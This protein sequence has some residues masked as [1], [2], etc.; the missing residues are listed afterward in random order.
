LYKEVVV[1]VA[2]FLR[3]QVRQWLLLEEKDTADAASVLPIREAKRLFINDRVARGRAERTIED[4]HRVLDPFVCWCKMNRLQTLDLTRNHIRSYIVVL[5]TKPRPRFNRPWSEGTV[6]LHIRYLRAFLNWMKG[7]DLVHTDLA[8]AVDAPKTVV[9]VN[10]LISDD[11]IMRLLAA[12]RSAPYARRDAALVLTFLDTGLRLHEVTLMRRSQIHYEQQDKYAW[13]HIYMPK[14]DRYRFAFLGESATQILK[15]Y[16][17]VR[18]DDNDALWLGRR[19]PL[20]DGGIYKVIK[21]RANQAGLRSV[22][23][24]ALR[25]M[26]STRWI[27]NGGDRQDL[28]DII[29]WIAPEMF[30]IYVQMTKRERL[31]AAHHQFSPVD[32]LFGED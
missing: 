18:G 15:H 7:E 20:T 26:F 10:G 9:N 2:S 1:T 21:R 4:Y 24:H 27:Q 28:Q 17:K 32:R 16:L 6:N 22:K 19:G 11:E 30:Q 23:P 8:G 25:K 12:C 5:R 13:L 29:G 31:S 14:T 3:N